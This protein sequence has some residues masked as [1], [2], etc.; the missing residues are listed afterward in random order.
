MIGIA[1]P[2]STAALEKRRVFSKAR[3]NQ[4]PG[5]SLG[6][7][8]ITPG[9]CPEGLRQSRASNSKGAPVH[10]EPGRGSNGTQ[11]PLFRAGSRPPPPWEA[12]RKAPSH[13]R[14]ADE[15]NRD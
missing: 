2:G 6:Q 1:P 13:P 8:R 11:G 14:F 5:K 4:W 10:W 9:D 7:A 15:C 12:A 3:H